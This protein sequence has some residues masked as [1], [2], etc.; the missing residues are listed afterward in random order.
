MFY[1]VTKLRAALLA[2]VLCF[3]ENDMEDG[4]SIYVSLKNTHS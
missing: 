4:V 3:S 2:F 1:S